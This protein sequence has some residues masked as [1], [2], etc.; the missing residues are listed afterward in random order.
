MNLPA[1]S[2]N[3]PCNT[4]SANTVIK[5][6]S[7]STI[8]KNRKFNSISKKD[9]SKATPNNMNETVPRLSIVSPQIGTLSQTKNP[10]LLTPKS[11]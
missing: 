8:D 11:L 6:D 4:K 2:V 1:Q 10:S 3:E 7:L 9:T 5:Q